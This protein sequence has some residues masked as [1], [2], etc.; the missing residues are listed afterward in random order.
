MM[1]ELKAMNRRPATRSSGS[2]RQSRRVTIGLLAALSA[3]VLAG[4][5]ATSHGQRNAHPSEPFAPALT[6]AMAVQQ[7]RVAELAFAKAMADRDFTAFMSHV[8]AN[9]IFFG[10]K[11]VEHGPAEIGAAWR[12]LFNDFEAPFSWA[13]DD[14]EVL[15]TG[16]LAFSTGPVVIKGKVVGRYNSV[17]RLE[18]GNTWRIVFD[19][20]ETVCDTH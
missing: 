20:G 4:G 2:Q 16:D 15:P 5:C 9:A 11:G 3:A 18:A 8:S 12:P 7:V 1:Y 6:A 13:P 10:G 19:K 17:W 14:I